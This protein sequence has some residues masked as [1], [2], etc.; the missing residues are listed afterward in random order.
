MVV[1]F[2][3]TFDV[4]QRYCKI[5]YGFAIHLIL[6]KGHVKCGSNFDFAFEARQ[7]LRQM[8]NAFVST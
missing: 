2:D 4:R 5:L 8:Y 7:R 6:V 3:I 1:T